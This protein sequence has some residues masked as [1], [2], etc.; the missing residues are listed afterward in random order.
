MSKKSRKRRK[1]ARA[2][3]GSRAYEAAMSI[4]S[5]RH[6]VNAGGSQD[7]AADHALE[8]I[9]DWGRYL[10]E[11]H[12]VASGILDNLCQNIVGTGIVTIPTPLNPDGSINEP[13][14]A[15]LMEIR[16]RWTRRVDVTG[17]LS[18]S[19]AQRMM[20]RAWMRDGEQFVQHV[21]GRER[22]FPFA[23]DMLPYRV[24]LLES[25]F[26][27]KELTNS[28]GWRQ[29]V[30]RDNWKRPIAYGFH[31]EHPDDLWLDSMAVPVVT[32][33]DVKVVPAELVTH[34]KFAKRWPATRGMS[35]FAPI[36]DRLYGLKDL[37]ESER[38]KNRILASWAAA[39]Q[40]SPDVP[41]HED[42]DS[43][44][45]RYADMFAGTL[46]DSLAPGES[47]VGVGPDYPVTGMPEH[48]ADQHRRIAAGTG[49]RYSSISRNYNGT[50]AAQRQELVEAEA[51]YQIREDY[52][53]GKIVREMHERLVLVAAL[54]G[55][56][57]L[58][59]GPDA[60]ERA[61]NAEYRGPATP[62]IDPWK[63]VQADAM[64]VEQGFA[65]IDQIRIK[66]GAPASMIGTP[67]PQPRPPAQLSLINDEEGAA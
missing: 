45:R 10:D 4:P 55:Q 50:Y 7:A 51:G 31:R 43:Q 21:A 19:E 12:D 34:I 61:A 9:R 27:P 41:G 14:G 37:E 49:T 57:M 3:E 53:V 18:E 23:R 46:I 40:K 16:R 13:L 22:G 17:E 8:R 66:R 52:F 29:G 48:I 56:I 59:T 5:R 24:E 65:D 11:N 63:E 20:C 35:V 36:I 25:E 1:A 15:R 47:I 30:R 62:F 54:D 44:G 39:I 33:E 26:C 6:V 32:A 2:D 67:A 42:T 38:I 60:L 28:D 64:A 58:D